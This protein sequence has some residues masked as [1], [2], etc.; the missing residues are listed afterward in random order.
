LATSRALTFLWS[1]ALF[2]LGLIGP[3]LAS[4]QDTPAATPA[5][6]AAAPAADQAT[7]AP[8][9]AAPAAAAA[10]DYNKGDV[11]WMLTSTLLVLMM[12]VPALALF[13][14]GMV[15]SKNMLSLAMQ[16]FVTFSLLSVLWAIYGYSIAFTQGNAFFGGFDRLF[17][18]GGF[19]LARASNDYVA[20]NWGGALMAGLGLEV[21]QGWN[22]SLDIESTV[23]GARY[24]DETW[25]NWS[26]VNFAINFF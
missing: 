1:L 23:T 12:A 25:I 10:P 21:V 9:E 3:D 15:R 26:L 22:W 24:D 4:A 6:E 2:A 7:A 17:L 13:Y 20:T 11:A 8:A 18:K 16:I 5:A 14:G 19:G